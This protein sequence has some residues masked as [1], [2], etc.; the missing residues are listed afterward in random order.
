M[1]G[2]H[3]RAMRNLLLWCDEAALVHWTSEGAEMPSWAEAHG[4]LQNEG[5]A[6]KVN[7]P[8][9]AHLAHKFPEPHVGR[10]SEAA[11]R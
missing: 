6:S 10:W 7:F 11:F 9:A 5:R 4:R 1:G 2:A 3:G 8:T